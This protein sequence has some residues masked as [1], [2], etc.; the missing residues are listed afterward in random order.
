VKHKI[1]DMVKLPRENYP[2]NILLI[3]KFSDK[4]YIYGKKLF[5]DS[6]V[7]WITIEKDI[8]ELFDRQMFKYLYF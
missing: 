7:F 1:G 5:L 8:I 4:S 3:T 2:F 6:P